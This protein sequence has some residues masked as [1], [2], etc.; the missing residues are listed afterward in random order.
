MRRIRKKE[1]EVGEGGDEVDKEIVAQG[2]E[3]GRNRPRTKVKQKVQVGEEQVEGEVIAVEGEVIVVE[4]E[5]IVVVGEVEGFFGQ[6]VFPFAGGAT[7]PDG[8]S[9]LLEASSVSQS[10]VSGGRGSAATLWM[11]SLTAALSLQELR[12]IPCAH[13]FHK[14][15]VDPWLLQHHTCPHCRHNIIGIM[16]TLQHIYISINVMYLVVMGDEQFSNSI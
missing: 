16:T 4:G 12:V 10:V 7:E 14:K 3:S 11:M 15:C 9:R 13:R 5:V 2:E 1:L 8:F 6:L